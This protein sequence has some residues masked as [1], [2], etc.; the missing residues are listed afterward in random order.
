MRYGLFSDF[1]GLIWWILIKFC[2]TKLEDEQNKKYWA[3]NIFVTIAFGYVLGFF[4][5]KFL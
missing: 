2:K 5:V 1:G 3:R 4:C